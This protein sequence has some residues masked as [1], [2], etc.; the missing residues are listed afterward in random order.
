MTRVELLLRDAARAAEW[1]TGMRDRLAQLPPQDL[2]QRL[3]RAHAA[4]LARRIY[5]EERTLYLATAL[6]LDEQQQQ[7]DREGRDARGI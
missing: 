7:Q 4:L 1:P 5:P 3:R 2:A 6:A